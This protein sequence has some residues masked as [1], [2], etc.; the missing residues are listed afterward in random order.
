MITQENTT[1]KKK[2]R[3]WLILIGGIIFLFL[4]LIGC[5]IITIVGVSMSAKNELT[6]ENFKFAD[7]KNGT[8]QKGDT[9][10][11]SCFSTGVSDD[12]SFH[13]WLIVKGKIQNDNTGKIVAQETTLG[14][15]RNS[16]WTMGGRIP[17]YIEAYFQ[18]NYPP[19]KYILI[20]TV[21]DKNNGKVQSFYQPFKII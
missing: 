2:S 18:V 5:G 21:T 4:G 7:G 11:F 12:D 8:Y 15:I 9:L 19:G 16:Y 1:K 13:I 3:K 10:K 20:L 17:V 6:I 14:E